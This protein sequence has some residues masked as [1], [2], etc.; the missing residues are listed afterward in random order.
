M[1]F[2]KVM[3]KM[4]EFDQDNKEKCYVRMTICDAEYNFLLCVIL[5]S[6][7]IILVIFLL[8]L[9]F[10]L[11]LIRDNE[12]EVVLFGQCAADAYFEQMQSGDDENEPVVAIVNLARISWS[13]DSIEP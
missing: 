11:L 9:T 8:I 12:I 13:L 3:G 6:S 2:V 10:P 7:C 5:L 1:G 4:G